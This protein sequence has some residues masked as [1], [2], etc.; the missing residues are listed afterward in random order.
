[1][2]VEQL[3]APARPCSGVSSS[4]RPSGVIRVRHRHTERFT[5]VGNHLAQHRELSLVA[6]GLGLHIQ[7]LPEGAKIGIKDLVRRFPEG[8][9]TVARALRELESYGYLSR[10]RERTAGNRWVTRTVVYDMPP[11]LTPPVPTRQPVPVRQPVPTRQPVP[12]PTPP[13]GVTA[14]RMPLPLP[15]PV[16]APAPP[17]L[18]GPGHPEPSDP[19]RH[20]AASELLA[21]LRS[22]DPRLLL[23]EQAIRR[24]APAVCAWLERGVEP[25]AVQRALADGL[26]AD[27]LRHPAGLIGHRLAASLPPPLPEREAPPRLDPI[28][29]C[30]RCERAFR[31]VEP[32]LCGSCASPGEDAGAPVGE[33]GG[34]AHGGAG[35][36]V[37][38]LRTLLRG[39]SGGRRRSGTAP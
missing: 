26:P 11:G 36:R 23:S 38:H 22:Y 4:V 35:V 18:P 17:V 30:E 9:V 7:S 28:Q 34:V 13:A 24:L 16:P 37:S 15:V 33:D 8:E 27:P 21:G 20:R 29:N 39:G 25:V 6:I 5:V 12:V 2:A 32:G 19:T 14:V 10:T 3:N 31:A 1:M